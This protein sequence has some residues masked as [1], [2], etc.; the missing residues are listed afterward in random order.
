MDEK[1]FLALE[2][3]AQAAFLNALA[4]RAARA[5]PAETRTFPPA[6]TFPPEGP[7]SDP[8]PDGWSGALAE[9][10]A[11]LAQASQQLLAG[12]ASGRGALLGFLNDEETEDDV[13]ILYA[14][15]Q[16]DAR[17]TAAVDIVAYAC[18]YTLRVTMGVA[19]GHPGPEVVPTPVQETWPE[20]IGYYLAQAE[21]LGLPR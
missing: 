5:V 10:L 7:V 19:P 3:K 16:G 4:L 6:R 1:T 9:T 18:A 12:D 21:L 20:F 2:E 17:A 14:A 11:T 15:Q 13:N 8:L